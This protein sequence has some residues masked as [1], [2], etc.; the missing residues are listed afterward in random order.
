[1]RRHPVSATLLA[2]LAIRRDRQSERSEGASSVSGTMLRGALAQAYLQRH[3]EPD[4]TFRLLFLDDSSCRLGPLDPAPRTLPLTALSCKR[5]PG[6]QADRKHGDD[7]HGMA[8]SLWFRIGQ[9]LAPASQTID[10]THCA[11]CDQD[12]KPE[13]GFYRDGPKGAAGPARKDRH[14]VATHVGID[15]A[16]TTAAESIFYTLEA[17]EP[18]L[19]PD[20]EGPDL[21]G[22]IEA[23]D[24]AFDSLRALL[25]GEEGVVTLGHARTRGYGRVQLDLGAPAEG[26]P[27]AE[28]WESWSRDLLEY[29][30]RPE[31]GIGPSGPSR[32]FAFALTLPTGAVLVDDLLRSSLDPAD[33]VEWLPRLS[34]VGE[35]DSVAFEGGRLFNLG[36]VARHERLRGWN[37]IH[38]LPRQDEWAIARGSVFA[39][40]L[41]GPAEARATLIERLEQLAR[42]GLGLRRGEGFGTVVVSDEFHRAFH[43]QEGAPP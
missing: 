29:L 8:D 16:S 22:W 5:E 33:D 7:K 35:R 41:D 37:A 31:F 11:R 43:Q 12:L 26:L 13:P 27:G 38:G 40:R 3:G 21:V 1:M 36:A 2:P 39:Y 6:F 42:D 20:S 18:S 30:A 14:A 15:R 4:P 9:W 10:P 25:D 19:A 23:N 32:S 17:L 24:A 34:E 28:A